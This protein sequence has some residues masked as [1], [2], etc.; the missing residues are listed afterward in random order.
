MMNRKGTGNYKT[1]KCGDLVTIKFDCNGNGG[2]SPKVDLYIN[3]TYVATLFARSVNASLFL[4]QKT[5][6][7]GDMFKLPR[8]VEAYEEVK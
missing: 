3:G 4:E 8:L 2:N 7:K 6:R 5:W 1:L